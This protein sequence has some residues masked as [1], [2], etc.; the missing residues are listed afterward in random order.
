MFPGDGPTHIYE[1]RK[2]NIKTIRQFHK[3]WHAFS[4][5]AMSIDVKAKAEGFQTY[6]LE[7]A[8]RLN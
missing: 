5:A 8:T 7:S 6:P 4:H 2:L 1:E 3:L